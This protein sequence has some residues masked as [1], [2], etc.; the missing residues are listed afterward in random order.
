MDRIGL[1][2][3]HYVRVIY[4]QTD[5][6]NAVYYTRYYEYFESA[7][8]ALLRSVGV[9]YADM[10]SAGY[11][12]PVVES[13]CRYHR[14]ATFE[15]ILIIE[16]FIGELPKVKLRLDYTVLRAGETDPIA[17]GY[18]VHSFVDAK[19]KPVRAPRQF[20][21]ALRSHAG[22]TIDEEPPPL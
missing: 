22:E 12:L 11:L 13:H 3:R 6:M 7:R 14:A 9:P 5:R 10:E 4:A 2:H 16:T 15:D 8:S 21:D 18:T 1:T 17:T 19:F 20:I